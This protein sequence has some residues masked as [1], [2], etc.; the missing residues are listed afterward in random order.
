MKEIDKFLDRCIGELLAR[1]FKDEHVD[2][3]LEALESLRGYKDDLRA[4]KWAAAICM[5]RT[6]IVPEEEI[7]GTTLEFFQGVLEDIVRVANEIGA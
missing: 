5:M 7:E 1:N 6:W 3:C 4:L 2:F